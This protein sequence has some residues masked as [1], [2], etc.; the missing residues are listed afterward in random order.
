MSESAGAKTA[1][2]TDLLVRQETPFN[3]ETTLRSLAGVITP[4]E[5]FFVRSHFATPA[6]WNGLTVSGAVE[7][8]LKLTVE[9]IKSFPSRTL[10][11]TIECAGNGRAFLDPPAAGVQWELG[12]VATAEWYGVP[13]SLLLDRAGMTAEAVEIVFRG[14]DSGLLAHSNLPLTFERSLSVL[15]ATHQDVLVAYEMNGLPLTPAHG[16][17]V[18]LVVP[19]W[20]GMASVKWLACI[21]VVTEPF[22]GHFQVEDYVIVGPDGHV[23][24]CR[25]IQPRAVTVAPKPGDLIQSG[26]V[27]VRGYCWAGTAEVVSVELTADAGQTWQTCAL[28]PSTGAY[29]WR[30]WGCEWKPPGIGRFH[31]IARA[32][33]AS[34]MI[35]PTGP[36]WNPLGYANNGA[37]PVTIEVRA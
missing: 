28:S 17:P 3:A 34:G 4:T 24:P 10:S 16:A 6:D 37:E 18:R 27:R 7:T 25:T 36:V 33:D 26:S 21:E 14:A 2:G 11:V 12:A 20:Y 13:L 23:D 35:Q 30:Q 32:R 9:E 22:L 19:G 31:L 1:G 15:D 5:S 29:T 8:P